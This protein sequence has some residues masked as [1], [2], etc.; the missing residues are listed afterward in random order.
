MVRKGI[1]VVSFKKEQ[2]M[3]EKG[4]TVAQKGTTVVSFTKEQ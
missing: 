4:T 1:A 3:R 2:Q